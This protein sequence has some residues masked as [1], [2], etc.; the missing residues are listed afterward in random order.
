M[1]RL[2][3]V[4]LILVIAFAITACGK[5]DD[6][7]TSKNKDTEKSTVEKSTENTEEPTVDDVVDKKFSAEYLLGSTSGDKYENEFLGLGFTLPESFSYKSEQEMRKLNSMTSDIIGEEYEKLVREA[8]LLYA[9]YAG[10]PDSSEN[11]NI[12]LQNVDA[13][14]LKNI[15]VTEYF[16]KVLPSVKTSL[17]GLGATDIQHEVGKIN[18]DGTDYDCL[19][20]TSKYGEVDLYQTQIVCIKDNYIGTITVTARDEESTKEIYDC[21]YV[22]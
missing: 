1:K 17:E 8:E 5:N 6:T 21:F 11:V 19:E 9:M 2:L 18:I 14:A 7:D 4:I 22:L 13:D 12:L 3:S 10:N 20:I 16:E 15:S